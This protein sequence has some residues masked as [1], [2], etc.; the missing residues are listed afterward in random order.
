MSPRLRWNRDLLLGPG[1]AALLLFALQLV[2]VPATLVVS[3]PTTGV[4]K[5]LPP[6]RFVNAALLLQA[7]A[8]V[9]YAFGYSPAVRPAPP[10]R[11]LPSPET[12]PT[13]VAAF[14]GLGV[15]GLALTFRS[16][17]ALGDYFTGRGAIVAEVHATTVGDAAGTF[18]RQFAYYGFV[19][20]W[21]SYLARRP[22][23]RRVSPREATVALLAVAAA[24]TY[25]YNRTTVLLVIIGLLTAYHRFG[26]RFSPVKLTVALLVLA[27]A[28]FEFGQYR[29]VYLGTQGGRISAADANLDRPPP[30]FTDTLQ[31]YANGPQ[32]WALTVAEVDRGGMLMGHTLLGSLLQP[33]PVLGK[34]FRADSGVARYNELIYHR[35][36]IADQNL[37]FGAELYWNFGLAGV[38]LGYVLLGLL[39]RRLDDRATVAADPLATYSWSYC[40]V[41]VALLTINSISVV[42]QAAVYFSWPILVMRVVDRVTIA[43]PVEVRI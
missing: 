7:L 24:A 8:Y 5:A 37:A 41:W 39:V 15:I 23:G 28:A 43:R 18:L 30:S 38:A 11:W 3:G 22:P 42:D 9:C 29:T 20:M 12:A 19:I 40:G 1:N 10:Q 33:V 25:D 16:L 14:L 17:G 36:G 32:F 26:R 34:P 27:L 2:V 31:V 35:T 21:A 4:L 6:D 13:V